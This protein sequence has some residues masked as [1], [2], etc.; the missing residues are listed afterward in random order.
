MTRTVALLFRFA[1]MPRHPSR[2]S[3]APVA[4]DLPLQLVSPSPLNLSVSTRIA[5]HDMAPSFCYPPP[6][7][8]AYARDD[9]LQHNSIRQRAPTPVISRTVV[10][11]L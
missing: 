10:R 9:L 7:R 1:T 6:V 11:N 2:N 3:Q 8:H 4:Y 5:P